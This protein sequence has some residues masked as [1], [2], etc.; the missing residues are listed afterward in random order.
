[1]HSPLH[2]CKVITYADD[3]VIFAS[4]SDIDAI[5]GNLSQDLDNLSAWFRE[6]ELIFNLKKGKTEV[7][8][9]LV[10]VNG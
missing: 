2:H 6:N 3:T 9:C 1:M 7:I 10:P 5:L 8:G 4:A